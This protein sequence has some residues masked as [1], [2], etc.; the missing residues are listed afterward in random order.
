ML[1]KKACRE[2]AAPGTVMSLDSGLLHA[3]QVKYIV[4]TAV[5]I[6]SHKRT[7]VLYIHDRERAAQGDLQPLWTMFH[8]KDGY[9]TLEKKEDGKTSWRTAAFGNLERDWFFVRNCAFYTPEDQRRLERYFGR[10]TG[11]GFFPLLWAQEAMMAQRLEQRLEKRRQKVRDRMACVPALPRGWKSWAYR[12]ALPSY[13][14]Y[15]YKR[16]RKAVERA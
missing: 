12:T 4:Q 11:H 8:C 16:G 15:D 6:I 5:K 13:F 3:E 10:N 14:F 2:F 1:D 7:L 9:I